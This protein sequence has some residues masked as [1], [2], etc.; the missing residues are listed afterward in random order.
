MDVSVLWLKVMC[1]TESAD[2]GFGL[3]VTESKANYTC[4][5]CEAGERDTSLDEN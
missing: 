3:V 1:E 5:R 2:L 4:P